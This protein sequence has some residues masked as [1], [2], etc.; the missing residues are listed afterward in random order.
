MTDFQLAVQN[1]V[2][3]TYA[4]TSAKVLDAWYGTVTTFH[5]SQSWTTPGLDGSGP[6]LIWTN[7]QPSLNNHYTEQSESFTT[8]QDVLEAISVFVLVLATILTDRAALV[9][10]DA[11][12][13]TVQGGFQWGVGRVRS[14]N[15]NDAPEVNDLASK[16]SFPTQ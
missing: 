11:L 9:M 4:Q 15:V 5:Q 16:L 1:F 10:V 7:T 14:Q 8:L 13:G 2:I 12:L 6:S 3:T